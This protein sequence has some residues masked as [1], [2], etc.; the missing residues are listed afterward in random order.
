MSQ[1]SSTRSIDIRPF[2]KQWDAY[3]LLWDNETSYLLYGGGAGGG[4][5]WLGCEWLITMSM[6]YPGIKSFIGR[7]RLKILKQS[8]L[9]T[10]FKVAKSLTLAR[11]KDYKY[12]Q[13]D[14]Y[15]EFA[16][17]SRIDLIEVKYNP[18]D[19]FYE[20]LGSTEYTIG[21]LEEA[22][23]IHFNAFDTLKARVGRHLNDKYGLH[24]K[25]LLTCNPKKNWLFTTF[26]LPW[27]KNVMEPG[28]KFLQ[29]LHGDNTKI[30]SSY[31]QALDEIKDAVKKQRLRDGI[32]EYE[33]TPGTLFD[34]DAITDLW[35]NTII[36]TT[37]L[38]MTVDVARSGQDKTV[39][40]FWKGL[41]LYRKETYS[42]QD[43]AIT[44]LKLKE[45]A[46]AYRIPYSHIVV[47][48]DGVGGG[49]VDN[50]KGVH[51]FVNNSSPL[52]NPK[53]F[54][55]DLERQNFENLKTQCAYI[56]ANRV[57]RHEVRIS[58]PE[59]DADFEEE[60]NQDLQI[61]YR[62]KRPDDD[63]RKIGLVSKEEIKQ[64][65]GRSPDYGDAFIMR[66]FFLLDTS[67]VSFTPHQEEER[68]IMRRM[69]DRQ[70]EE[71]D[72]LSRPGM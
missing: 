64:E 50:C 58:I 21:W 46:R 45:A 70:P 5:S 55:E 37:D 18:S 47:D 28:Y 7:E 71:G 15:I 53:A 62:I 49:V 68:A 56:M 19:P 48:E 51:G 1:T 42:K 65:L 33:A 63:L 57:N 60:F 20:D 22:G 26:Y 27:K 54:H 36:E 44:S 10:F 12:N 41:N 35:T 59:I 69:E 61:G 66:G 25:I 34:Y 29:S 14:S 13:Q 11:D 38:Y 9:Q 24:R 40:Y 8:T 4:K 16:N 32:W 3:Q 31:H 30:E 67:Y 39:F 72:F 43:I 2:Q 17:G 23:E 6:R 52:D